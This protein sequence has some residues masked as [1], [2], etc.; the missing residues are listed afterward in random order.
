REKITQ[1]RTIKQIDDEGP[2]AN[3]GTPHRVIAR[4]HVGAAD[5]VAAT[6]GGDNEF[7]YCGGVAQAQIESLRT[8]GRN[9]MGGFANQCNSLICK[10]RRCSDVKR[11]QAPAWLEFD[12]AEN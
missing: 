1:Q 2:A 12:F 5:V 4:Q 7:G 11:K 10:A 8:D 9:D 6:V 3:V